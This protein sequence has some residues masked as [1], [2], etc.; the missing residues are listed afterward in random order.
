MCLSSHIIS[1]TRTF[2]LSRRSS[3]AI[4]SMSYTEHSINSSSR[5][6]VRREML[7][8]LKRARRTKPHAAP[9]PTQHPAAVTPSKKE[10][11]RYLRQPA[12][13]ESVLNFGV[14]HGNDPSCWRIREEQ[15]S[16]YGHV[17]ELIEVCWV[18]VSGVIKNVP[19]GSYD[20]VWR[21]R[22]DE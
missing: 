6:F 18:E 14:C 16:P 11:F 21:L 12:I 9:R 17:R 4:L 20:C 7:R 8:R 5:T 1:E 19:P 3:C 22:I 2:D 15:S 13:R 10:V